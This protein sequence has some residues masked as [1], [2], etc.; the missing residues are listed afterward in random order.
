MLHTGNHRQLDAS[1]IDMQNTASQATTAPD[2]PIK[3]A[4]TARQHAGK[5]NAGWLAVKRNNDP[6]AHAISRK[7]MQCGKRHTQQKHNRT[8]QITGSKQQIGK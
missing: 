8:R 4:S 2:A 5:T 7:A 6:T 3:V 1:D